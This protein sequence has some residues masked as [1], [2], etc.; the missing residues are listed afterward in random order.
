[1]E[2]DPR[3]EQFIKDSAFATVVSTPN[4]P[5]LLIAG[6]VIQCTGPYGSMAEWLAVALRRLS[7]GVAVAQSEPVA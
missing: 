2:T 6:D 5:G 3:I 1:M 4:G 7:S